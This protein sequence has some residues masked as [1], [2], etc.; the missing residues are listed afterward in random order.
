MDESGQAGNQCRPV[1]VLI[2]GLKTVEALLAAVNAVI[3]NFMVPDVFLYSEKI[4][5]Q[6]AKIH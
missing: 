3:F 1:S 2:S 4:C 6:C 5:V